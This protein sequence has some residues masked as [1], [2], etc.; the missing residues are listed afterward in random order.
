MKALSFRVLLRDARA[1][2]LA[3]AL[4][5][6]SMPGAGR[7]ED[8]ASVWKEVLA[9]DS[10]PERGAKEPPTVEMF[11]KHLKKQEAV[12]RRFLALPDGGRQR[13][14]AELRLARVL[15]LRAE[16]E[17]NAQ[18]QQEAA[19][20]LDR[21]EQNATRE[22]Q[23]HVAFTRICQ[24][25]R[26]TRLP[27][28]EQRVELLAAVREFR[29][30]FAFDART[31]QLLV[32]AATRFDREPALKESLLSDAKQLT[33][34][35]KLKL[36]ITDDLVR[37]ALVGRELKLTFPDHSGRP[38]SIEKLRGQPVLLFFF[39]ADIV[40]SLPVW[41]KL[42]GIL[43]AYPAVT[44]VALSLDENR[45]LME[46]ARQELGAGWTV[47]WEA[48][49]WKSPMARRWGI[50]A[51]PTAFLLDAGGRVFS[52]NALDDLEEQLGLLKAGA[53]RE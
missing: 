52:I 30:R 22:Q 46:R 45:S 39:A 28:R 11:S 40:P 41:K 8:A 9:L 29:E 31:P 4:G 32:E 27:N 6:G 13:F 49:G 50:N 48:G 26:R 25:M 14:E 53:S 15:A 7:A 16:Q 38:V 24:W 21:L 34:D 12:L 3:A 47:G 18:L 17:V 43:A 2:M 20:L 44:R 10:G 23:A 36:R 35:P 51:V 19:A 1:L 42:N 37:T 5:A 33:R